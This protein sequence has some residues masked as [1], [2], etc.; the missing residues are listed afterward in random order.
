MPVR[1]ASISG[2]SATTVSALHTSA[3]S[4]PLSFCV[5]LACSARY[6]DMLGT[7]IGCKNMHPPA[8]E[9]PGIQCCADNVGLAYAWNLY[10]CVQF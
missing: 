4:A 6:L 9:C 1:T 7:A 8:S 2:P 10:L 3:S 5:V